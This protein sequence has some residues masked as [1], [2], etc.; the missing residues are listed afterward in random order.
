MKR[1]NQFYNYFFNAGTV[2]R[3]KRLSWID[4][5]KGLTIVLVVYHHSFVTLVHSGVNV[6]PWLINANLLVYSFRMPMFFML[7]GLFIVQSLRK[8][9]VKNYIKYRFKYILYPYL[10]WAF[11]QATIGIFF[12]PYLHGS[13]TLHRYLVIFYE[14]NATSQLWYLM[15]LFNTAIL[16]VFLD[17]KLK[18]KIWH[19]LAL[20]IV[21]YLASPFLFF[22]SMIQDTTRFYVYLVFGS[23]ISKFILDKKNFPLISSVRLLVPLLLLMVTSQYYLHKNLY[24]YKLEMYIDIH[25]LS[26]PT[27]LSHFWGMF[28]FVVIVMIGCAFILNVCALFQKV[29][30]SNFIRVIGYH[31]LYIYILHVLLVVTCRLLFVNI[32]HYENAFIILPVQILTG[33]IGAV[34]IYNLCRHLNM[35]FLYEYDPID[36]KKFF[37]FPNLILKSEKVWIKTRPNIMRSNS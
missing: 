29:G 10:I 6:H 31:S 12:E 35:N 34:M 3:S 32:L 25:S 5:A 14:P 16:F 30:K 17:A 22:N 20:G 26:I 37:H 33:T 21:L 4:Y 11:I 18:L 27:V 15:T 13:W 28:Q 8:R 9:G 2:L 19:Q 1:V 36:L 24:L 7:S 23:L